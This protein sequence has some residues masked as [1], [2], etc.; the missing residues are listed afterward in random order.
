M[1]PSA[2]ARLRALNARLENSWI[3]DLIGCLSLFALLY[4]G[5]LAALVFQ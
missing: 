2:W 5:L 1:R 3:G 4:I